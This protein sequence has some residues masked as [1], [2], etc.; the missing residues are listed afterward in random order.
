MIKTIIRWAVAVCLWSLGMLVI[1][2][3]WTPVVIKY[4]LPEQVLGWILTPICLW[5][6]VWVIMTSVISSHYAEIKREEL[7]IES[8]AQVADNVAVLKNE[9]KY[10][11]EQFE[12]FKKLHS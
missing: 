11:R 1:S 3:M 9:F 6:V 2:R 7:R 5:S 12:M 8:K 4:A 10:L